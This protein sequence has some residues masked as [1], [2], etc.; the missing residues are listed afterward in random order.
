MLRR[1]DGIAAARKVTGE[2]KP[3]LAALTRRTDAALS[4]RWPGYPDERAIQGDFGMARLY[5][6]KALGLVTE[7][8]ADEWRG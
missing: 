5:L 7:L 8:L 4:L 3:Y 6:A 1:T 2:A